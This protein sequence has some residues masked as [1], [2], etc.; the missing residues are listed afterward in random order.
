[1][2]AVWLIIV[3]ITCT[4]AAGICAESLNTLD[5]GLA[6]ARDGNCR[7]ALVDLHEVIS[8]NPNSIPALNAIGFCESML[9]HPERGTSSFETI[10][11]LQPQAWQAWNNLGA[12]YLALSRPAAAEQAFRKA[13]SLGPT[14][15][16]AWSNLAQAL[17]QE[18]N[19]VEAF[20]A[21]DRAQQTDPKD[22]RLNRAWVDLA[23]AIATEAGNDIDKGEYAGAYTKLS[24]VERPL[25]ATA[26]WNNLIGYAEFKL[27]KDEDAQ[28]HLH[29]AL[30]KDPD[31]EDYLL[32]V[33][34]FLAAHHA[35]AEAAQFFAVGAK[36]MPNSQRVRFGVAITEL[37]LD[38]R[39]EA[40]E[41]L[42]RLRSEYPGW[43]PVYRALGECYED[44]DNWSALIQLG[45]VMQTQ[46]PANPLGWYFEGEGQERLSGQNGS[47]VAAAID[48]LRRAVALDRSS[49][50]Y[51][52]E[53][54]KAYAENKDPEGA[55]RELKD[56]IRIDPDHQRAHYVLARVYQQLGER[57]LAQLEFRAHS[58][59]KAQGEKDAYVAILTT[60]QHLRAES[61][62]ST[63]K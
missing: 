5:R 34:E 55:V 30:E 36:R 58:R 54:G 8:R 41:L 49:S 42:E 7:D 28:R 60:T 37:L 52:F 12:N 2:S 61:S 57:K 51:H 31:N 33:G 4:A 48:L 16:A 11:K 21:L 63:N 26:S 40:T 13:V 10:V 45:R 35:Y 38:R 24:L 18:G 20:R 44:T 47:Q 15:T 43:E 14:A 19:K 32:D 59:I 46:N 39:Q 53:L 62:A 3:G 23:A 6:E 25:H 50:R 1:M 56:A 9:S 27:N 29:A 22:A 17:L